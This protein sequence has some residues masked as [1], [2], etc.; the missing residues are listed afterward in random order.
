MI[1]DGDLHPSSESVAAEARRIGERDRLDTEREASPLRRPEGAVE[2]DTTHLG[3]EEQV[4]A[5]LQR[6]NNLTPS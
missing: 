1:Q 6:V 4:E 3:F 2:L 5:I